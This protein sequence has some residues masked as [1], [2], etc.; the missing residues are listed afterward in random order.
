MVMDKK[1][2]KT[3]QR[4]Q[5]NADLLWTNEHYINSFVPVDGEHNQYVLYENVKVPFCEDDFKKIE[6]NQFFTDEN[7]NFGKIDSLEWL[8]YENTAILNYRVNELYTD[9]LIQT[10]L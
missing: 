5:F 8:P 9:K 3:N 1:E 10:K 7:G 2:L 6:E 4:D